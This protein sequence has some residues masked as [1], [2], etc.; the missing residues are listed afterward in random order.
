M[1]IIHFVIIFLLGMLIYSNTFNN[2]FHFDEHPYIEKNQVL[3]HPLDVK[4]LWNF[5]PTR[6][7]TYLSLS[8][9]YLIGQLNVF[10]YHL[11]NIIIHIGSSMLVYGLALL[12][13]PSFCLDKAQ[14]K[15]R[16]G[17]LA[18]FTALV[19]LLHPLQTEAV[20]YIIQRATLLA[21]FFYLLSFILYLKWRLI[22]QEGA[23]SGN[24]FYYA[25]SLFTAILAMF[26]KEISVTLPLMIILSDFFLFPGK[27][28]SRRHLLPFSLLILVIPLTI[29]LTKFVNLASML[30]PSRPLTGISFWRYLFTQ[31]AVLLTYLRL[32][33][34]PLNQNVDYD[35]PIADSLLGFS[36]LSGLFVILVIFFCALKFSLKYKLVSFGIFWFFLTLALESGILPLQD[37]IA[38]HRLY[39]AMAG[40]GIF[41]V[42]GLHYLL[43]RKSMKAMVLLLL[44][45]FSWFCFLTYARNFCWKDEFSL[46]NDA[47][48]KSPRKARPY[49]NRGFALHNKGDI[50][51]AIRDYDTA[52]ILDPEYADAY[53]NRGLAYLAEKKFS[54]AAADFT[55]A[56]K[57]NPNDFEFYYNR[58]FAYTGQGEYS[59]AIADFNSALQIN[60]RHAYAYYNRAVAY[61]YRKEYARAWEDMQKA[62]ESGAKIEEAFLQDLKKAL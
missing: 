55:A 33:F 54:A 23:R 40:Y 61:F 6:F 7:L 47:V 39:L 10:G 4:A 49:N 25:A 21:A 28:I 50:K 8:L 24:R 5:C 58:G 36:S 3:R 56:I 13:F 42:S 14:I 11:V 17:I 32:L 52:I 37:V 19:F 34:L 44:F 60:P 16:A 38:E 57:I 46:W 59:L 12:L 62:R 27:K 48:L 1:K 51:R 35:Y 22:R 15:N 29:I 18:L 41:L 31:P 9:N 45:L 43:G 30:S 20:T 26:S 2:S 53:F